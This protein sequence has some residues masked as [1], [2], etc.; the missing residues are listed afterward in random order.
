MKSGVPVRRAT[1]IRKPTVIEIK[2]KRWN[3]NT[4]KMEHDPY[5]RSGRYYEPQNNHH[6]EIREN[7]K[8]KWIGEV[9]TT[10]EAAQRVRPANS[11]M[12]RPQ[13]AVNHEDA[14]DGKFVMSL[15]I[16]EM[17]YMKHPETGKT[18]YFVVFKIDGTGTIH[19]AHTGTQGGQKQKR[20]IP[21]EKM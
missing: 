1:L 4:G 7:K 17:V 8:G 14:K 3:P 20:N 18:D 15:S 12:Q 11:S 13:S 5:P 16:G 2:R 6:I 19:F 21:Q 10:F 9:I